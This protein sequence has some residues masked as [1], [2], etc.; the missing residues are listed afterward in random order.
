MSV[1]DHRPET[2]ASS[3]DGHAQRETPGGVESDPWANVR[4][5][6]PR[7]RPGI[8][9]GQP[10]R[11]PAL[12]P[13][14]LDLDADPPPHVP[15]AL[16]WPSF[17]VRVSNPLAAFIREQAALDNVTVNTWMVRVLEDRRRR[18]ERPAD[19]RDWLLR[20]AAQCGAPGDPEAALVAVVR[21]LAERWPDGARLR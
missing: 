10:E 3:L 4:K 14:V 8:R 15:R 19:V 2:P 9:G 6:S 7:S 11:P 20:Q 13:D 17:T 16:R 1:P 18:R 21:H 12:D 5:H